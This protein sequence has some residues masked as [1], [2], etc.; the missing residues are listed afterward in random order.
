MLSKDCPEIDIF[1]STLLSAIDVA[2]LPAQ[3]LKKNN[4]G[5][6]NRMQFFIIY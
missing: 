3:A 2:E 6:K 1:G 4:I 5:R